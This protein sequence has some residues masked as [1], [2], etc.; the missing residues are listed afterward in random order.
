[1][2]LFLAVPF[3]VTGLVAT[4]RFW[5]NWLFFDNYMRTGQLDGWSSR[6]WLAIVLMVIYHLGALLTIGIGRNIRAINKVEEHEYFIRWFGVWVL[7]VPVALAI[8]GFV[9]QQV[10]A[11]GSLMAKLMPFPYADFVY[12]M[13][14]A[15]AI[16]AGVVFLWGYA[17][18]DLGF[19]RYEGT[20]FAWLTMGRFYVL[21]GFV[22]LATYAQAEYTNSSFDY[23]EKVGAS[24]KYIFSWDLFLQISLPGLVVTLLA[25]L[26]AY[27]F[28]LWNLGYLKIGRFDFTRHPD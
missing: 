18:R 15:G 4:G 6:D 9:L 24:E 10:D 5:E 20:R 16:G 2:R 25:M 13:L 21:M 17:L 14:I 22:F 11:F 23:V 3:I 1:M 28:L 12:S 19:S 7:V 8:Y 27:W 26:G